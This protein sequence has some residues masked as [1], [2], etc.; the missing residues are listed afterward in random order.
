MVYI[1]TNDNVQLA[2]HVH[3]IGQP[4]ILIAGD[5]GNQA[6]WTAQIPAFVAAG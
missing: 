6:T 2:Y 5:S 4:I 3:G 1:T